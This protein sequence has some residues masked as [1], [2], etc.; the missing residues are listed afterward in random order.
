MLGKRSRPIQRTQN[1]SHSFMKEKNLKSGFFNAPRIF[2]GFALKYPAEAAGDGSRSPTS[3]LECRRCFETV[4]SRSKPNAAVGLGILAALQAE[5]GET[6]KSN[7]VSPKNSIARLFFKEIRQVTE[8]SQPIPI[9]RQVVKEEENVDDESELEFSES[10]TCVTTHGSKSVTKHVYID[11]REIEVVA[12]SKASKATVFE[13][14]SFTDESSL[15]VA[16]FLSACFLCGRPL[17]AGKDI[18]MY[19]FVDFMKV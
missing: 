16:D 12:S 6:A 11:N 9:K 19:R 2:I 7:V 13:A 4:D 5:S 14:S 3:P 10:Y 1:D 18:Y 8:K 17:C 15:P